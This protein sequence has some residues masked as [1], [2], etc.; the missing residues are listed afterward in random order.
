[1][2]EDLKCRE[3]GKAY[4]AQPAAMCEECFGP[5]EFNVDY[6]QLAGILT[7]EKIA[8]RAK[9]MWRYRELLPIT[10]VP[11]PGAS[12]GFTPLVVANNLAKHWGVQELYIKN[13]AVNFP[14]LSF[15]DRV[16][17]VAIAK[18]IDFGFK[19]VGC[20]STGNLANAVAAQAAA[21]RL[22]TC[23]LIPSDLEPAKIT[24]TLIYGANL[25]AVTGNY[26]EVNRLCT[27]IAERYQWGF[28]NVNLRP[29]YAEGSKTYGF[30]ILEQLGWKTPQHIIVP[31]AG[32][33]LITKIQ[34]AVQEFQKLGLIEQSPCRIYGAQAEGCA[35]IVNMVKQG[36]DRLR[37]VKPNTIAK[38]LAIGNP[39]DGIYAARVMR[40]SG[41]TGESATDDEIVAG[42][43]LLATTEG[44]FTET[45]GGVMIAAAEKL[46]RSGKIPPDES[47]VLSITGNGLKTQ[48]A[49]TGSVKITAT[50]KP[51][52]QD[53]QR[54]YEQGGE[55]WQ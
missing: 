55:A 20:A 36:L 24:G 21:C 12:I 15:K 45:A 2:A 28:V 33:S 14:S 53:F 8:Q 6:S 19:V 10:N 37:P 23:I 25:I 49:I 38:S 51:T 43:R 48:D 29:Y 27:Q 44:I 30:E 41:G 42:I 17:S 3:C 4:S 5:L 1:M 7:R 46:I 39:A 18:A 47:I 35:P 11:A 16:V 50:I 13:D 22:K 40:Q 9:N 26:D 54:T 52:F 34:K 32:G 31:M